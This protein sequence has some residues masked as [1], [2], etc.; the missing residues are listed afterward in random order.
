MLLPP[1]PGRDLRRVLAAHLAGQV[2]SVTG[3]T[4][5]VPGW[6]TGHYRPEWT[7]VGRRRP[8]DP[9][10]GHLAG[11]LAIPG[12]RWRSTASTC[13]HRRF[14]G[15][16][17][18]PPGCSPPGRRTSARFQ[19][20]RPP[21]FDLN[22]PHGWRTDPAVTRSLGWRRRAA[23]LAGLTDELERLRYEWTPGR[24]VRLPRARLLT[25]RA[26]PDD[27]VFLDAFRRIAAGSLD[28]TTRRDVAALGAGRQAREDMQIYLSMPGDRT[29]WRLAYTP[30]GALAGLA[31][32]SRMRA[33]R[34]SATSASCP[35]C[36]AG[37]TSMSFWAR[38][39]GSMRPR[40]RSGSWR[41][42]TRATWR[43]PPRSS[44]PVTA[45]TAS[46]WCC[47]RPVADAL[48]GGRGLG[49]PSRPRVGSGVRP[50]SCR[51]R[52]RPYRAADRRT[53]RPRC[54]PCTSGPSGLRAGRHVLVAVY[55]AAVIASLLIC[56]PPSDVVG[57]R[58]VLTA[59][60]LVAAAGVGAARGGRVRSSLAARGPGGQ[61]LA[62]G[63]ASGALT[64]GPVLTEPARAAG[65]GVVP[66]R[67]RD[68]GGVRHRARAGGISA[69]AQ[70]AAAPGCCATWWRSGCWSPRSPWWPLS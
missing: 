19:A 16:A 9:G 15:P 33:G 68:H 70:F 23:S 48:P 12:T 49:G 2:G 24:A 13:T 42:P 64:A 4:A 62:V 36:A 67:D 50:R 18:S 59:S 28:V 65:Q 53:C 40:G 31:I 26:E 58:P 56:G 17:R 51:A 38:S 22:V 7:W 20:P 61:G 11:L 54:M 27:A 34:W 46:G 10:L 57:Y 45:F 63:S 6:L 30:G 3:P 37:V 55:A 8:P 14:A 43:W 5:T 35:N 21:Q 69:L 39:P 25:F 41:P 66:R 1:P 29:W 60:L 47:P 44:G 32:P 52:L